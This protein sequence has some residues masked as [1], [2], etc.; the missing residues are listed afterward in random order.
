MFDVQPGP[1][2][3]RDRSDRRAAGRRGGRDRRAWQRRMQ[4]N[5]VAVELRAGTERR[6]MDRR[7]GVGRRIS[8]NR[9]ALSFGD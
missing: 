6:T 9:R 5:P 8:G 3:R 2:E 1:G 4:F 7:T